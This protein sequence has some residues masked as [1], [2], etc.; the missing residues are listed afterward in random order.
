ML[1]YGIRT[2]TL[3]VYPMYLSD[4]ALTSEQLLM[5]HFKTSQLQ[6]KAIC[7]NVLQLTVEY[8]IP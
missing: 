3:N 8:L 2:V 7:G 6:F 5:L 4:T 1:G